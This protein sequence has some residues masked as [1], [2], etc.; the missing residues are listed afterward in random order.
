MHTNVY[1]STAFDVAYA[2]GFADKFPSLRAAEGVI[3]ALVCCS[4]YDPKSLEH[5]IPAEKLELRDDQGRTPLAFAVCSRQQNDASIE[6]LINKGADAASF[7]MPDGRTNLLH[8]AVRHNKSPAVIELLFK[9]HVSWRCNSL[10]PEDS[11]L[12]A[13]CAVGSLPLVR[14]LLDRGDRPWTLID[15]TATESATTSG[16]SS[17]PSPSTTTTTTTS[18]C[19]VGIF[20]E[21]MLARVISSFGSDTSAR[22]EALRALE[23]AGLDI[24]R[25]IGSASRHRLL[26]EAVRHAQ[27][28]TVELL[29]SRD[30]PIELD[31]DSSEIDQ[32][33]S[34]RQGSSAIR[35]AMERSYFS[36]RTFVAGR[37]GLYSNILVQLIKKSIERG[38]TACANTVSTERGSLLYHAATKLRSKELVQFLLEAGADI[39]LTGR[40]NAEGEPCGMLSTVL[41]ENQTWDSVAELLLAQGASPTQVDRRGMSPIHHVCHRPIGDGQGSPTTDP[42]GSRR[43]CAVER[44]LSRQLAV[45]DRISR[46][47]AADDGGDESSSTQRTNANEYARRAAQGKGSSRPHGTSTQLDGTSPREQCTVQRASS[48]DCNQAPRSRSRSDEVA[49]D[50]RPISV[51]F[52]C[53]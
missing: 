32:L 21:E 35:I 43:Q 8:L 30:S 38:R 2:R 25:H 14:L 45:L 27:H 10:D 29:L 33:L 1:G 50:H 6:W 15:G 34:S 9:S 31:D 18:P 28:Q 23:A 13:A 4:L 19:E 49:S 26:C 37:A 24:S 39:N 42:S 48:R 40:F 17:S 16:S 47:H 3:F 41:L 51:V 36:D 46:H 5:W 11:L 52:H 7:L 53:E 20:C 44:E 22:M 12:F